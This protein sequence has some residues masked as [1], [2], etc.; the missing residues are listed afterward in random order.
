MRVRTIRAAAL[1]KNQ[2][3]GNAKSEKGF[4]S[5]ALTYCGMLGRNLAAELSTKLECPQF[6]HGGAARIKESHK[7]RKLHLNLKHY[8]NIRDV[9]VQRTRPLKPSGTWHS[10]VDWGPP[11][12]EAAGGAGSL[13]EPGG[14]Q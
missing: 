8:I 12:G 13:A 11:G 14:K 4:T 2:A 6:C 9:T 3:D 7:R 10:T 5:G 1:G